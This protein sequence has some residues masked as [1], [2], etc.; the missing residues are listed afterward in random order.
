MFGESVKEV[1]SAGDEMDKKKVLELGKI[2]DRIADEKLPTCE[3][4]GKKG[5]SDICE[6]CDRT[7]CEECIGE[8]TSSEQSDDYICCKDCQKTLEIGI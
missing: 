1:I 7:I 5:A 2:V 3:I 4:C 6:E 8:W